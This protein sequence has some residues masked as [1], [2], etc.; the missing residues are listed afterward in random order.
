MT[1]SLIPA[2]TEKPPPKERT[3]AHQTKA[4]HRTSVQSLDPGGKICFN[5]ACSIALLASKIV[6]DQRV[7]FFE[8]DRHDLVEYCNR[9]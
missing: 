4:N 6:I 3:L 8:P 5:I 2:K 1:N 9:C 7:E